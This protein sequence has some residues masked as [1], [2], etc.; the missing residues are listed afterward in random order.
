MKFN[1][2]NVILDMT[3]ENQEEV[4]KKI[5]FVAEDLGFT[6]NSTKL[7]QDFLERE[8]EFSTGF[9]NG[10]AIP[11]AKSDDVKE[12]TVIFARLINP[13]D[14][15]SM[16]GAPVKDIISIMV[17]A[18]ASKEHLDTLAKLSRQIIHSEFIEKLNTGNKE[19]IVNL[20]KTTIS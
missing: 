6:N 16:D 3:A 4:L 13:V 18:H 12:A 1:S 9:G 15:N 17:P 2:D 10:I 14:W 5:S 7:T 20:I 11:H 8:R 19:E